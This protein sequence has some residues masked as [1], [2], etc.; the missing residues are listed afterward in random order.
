MLHSLW[1]INSYWHPEVSDSCAYDCQ[2]NANSALVI[3]SYGS[4]WTQWTTFQTGA[5]VQYLSDAAYG[6]QNA[7]VDVALA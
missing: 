5:Y 2:C 3:S 1:Q 4:S 7:F 6:C